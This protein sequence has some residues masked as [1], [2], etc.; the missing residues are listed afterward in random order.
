MHPL[1]NTTHKTE[2]TLAFGEDD[3]FRDAITK[4]LF[5]SG[6]IETPVSIQQWSIQENGNLQ[7]FSGIIILSDTLDTQKTHEEI[8]YV[9]EYVFSI[10]AGKKYSPLDINKI[11]VCKSSNTILA[12]AFCNLHGIDPEDT[13]TL[14]EPI[15]FWSTIRQNLRNGISRRL[16]VKPIYEH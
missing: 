7:S 5:F 14:N 9:L 10:I 12:S 11:L 13:C 8:G 15:F 16:L 6:S 1:F 3:E 4:A 2:V